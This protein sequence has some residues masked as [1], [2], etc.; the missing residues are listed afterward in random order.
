MHEFLNA[1]AGAVI[2]NRTIVWTFCN[3]KPCLT[4]DEEMCGQ[5]VTRLPWMAH[6]KDIEEK[7]KSSGCDQH[8]IERVQ[9]VN[10]RLRYAAE[11]ILTCCG[12]EKIQAPFL[13]YGGMDRREMFALSLP[14]AKLSETA[15][16]IA[17]ILFQNGEDEGYGMLF[18]ST[19]EFTPRIADQNANI[20]QK[21]H[22]TLHIQDRKD[23]FHIGVHLRHS[24]NRDLN[25]TEYG[26]LKCIR[27]VLSEIKPKT[28]ILLVA[29]DRANTLQRMQEHA[30]E[31]N[32][33]FVTSNHS[34]T[35]AQYG[36]HGPF[37]GEIAMADIELL[38]HADYFIG[39]SYMNFGSMT[40]TYSMLISGLVSTNRGG[41]IMPSPVVDYK[42]LYIQAKLD[43][44]KLQ[45]DSQG[46]RRLLEETPEAERG[47]GENIKW[48]PT[49]DIA[50]GARYVPD[51]MY[52]NGGAGK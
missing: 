16:H 41:Y 8:K 2:T 7:W 4:D 13:D 17:R 9:V 47:R 6:L 22:D 11:K 42:E 25:G 12:L 20:L 34:L 33:T 52:A 26:E 49:C 19:F 5:F 24:N 37:W 36:E 10:F 43:L 30:R 27:K 3:R 40:S 51:K 46:H 50:V 39:S 28:C 44:K 23:V 32:C 1:W 45:S 35:H 31:V 21:V 15:K 48:L 29:S 18:R 14:A 38:S